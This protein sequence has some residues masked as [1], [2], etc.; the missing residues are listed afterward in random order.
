MPA[1]VEAKSVT[2]EEVKAIFLGLR[3]INLELL[4]E[5]DITPQTAINLK[6]PEIMRLVKDATAIIFWIKQQR[7]ALE[8][9]KP[10]D[11]KQLTR[12][13]HYQNEI[14]REIQ[15][16]TTKYHAAFGM[17]KTLPQE[18]LAQD[19]LTI[20]NTPAN[21]EKII[22][23][24]T[25]YY[26]KRNSYL[27][28]YAVKDFFSNGK[29]GENK[30]ARLTS[31]S[32]TR[33][34][35]EKI[36]KQGYVADDYL[37]GLTL[38][39]VELNRI[40]TET[41]RYKE[42]LLNAK[43]FL[44]E[45]LRQDTD[46]SVKQRLNSLLTEQIKLTAHQDLSIYAKKRLEQW[47]YALSDRISPDTLIQRI[48]ASKR[49]ALQVVSC[50]SFKDYLKL[51]MALD[52]EINKVSDKNSRLD[53]RLTALKRQVIEEILLPGNA[54][55]GL[56][57]QQ[58]KVLE[59]CGY[60]NKSSATGLIFTAP[61]ATPHQFEYK[62]A[63]IEA[64]NALN[65]D[66]GLKT[67]FQN[68]MAQF[69]VCETA[70]DYID[71]WYGLNKVE[72]NIAK[73]AAINEKI[74]NVIHKHK[75]LVLEEIILK[76]DFP[77]GL[78]AKML[79]ELAAASK[80]AAALIKQLSPIPKA[81]A[82]H[83]K[84]QALPAQ[85]NEHL[86]DKQLA[87]FKQM[88]IADLSAKF[89]ANHVLGSGM[90][91]FKKSRV[92]D[93]FNI[94]EAMASL[95]AF[96]GLPSMPFIYA[97]H[98]VGIEAQRKEDR[99]RALDAQKVSNFLH[100][101]Q[102]KESLETLYELIAQKI[103]DK[104]PHQILQIKYESDAYAGSF[105]KIIDKLAKNMIRNYQGAQPE[106]TLKE[107]A[108]CAGDQQKLK[109]L[110][111]EKF[112]DQLVKGAENDARFGHH[113]ATKTDRYGS[114]LGRRWDLNSMF[115]KTGCV[116]MT[117]NGPVFFTRDGA[118]PDKYGYSFAGSMKE[119]KDLNFK[120]DEKANQNTTL[121]KM[122]EHLAD[123]HWEQYEKRAEKVAKI[124]KCEAII[125]KQEQTISVLKKWAC[126]LGEKIN[127]IKQN[128]IY[129]IGKINRLSDMTPAQVVDNIKNTI[130]PVSDKTSVKINV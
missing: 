120:L 50:A 21:I 56:S 62:N 43:N 67:T 121:K 73:S 42:L 61:L 81:I 77:D 96:A 38:I 102:I 92:G 52:E 78:T 127:A 113:V 14:E 49:I 19:D 123:K 40:V 80:E 15:A 46:P 101:P 118:K 86:E 95:I 29:T 17:D 7:S 2:I 88:L 22:A 9:E 122:Y 110:W 55:D 104:Y 3:K 4:T 115:S 34:Y 126:A 23:D 105:H 85:D 59:A 84:E 103:I 98:I 97:V 33:E 79:K 108:D 111:L 66:S 6:M 82:G 100:D 28:K 27:Q 1:S 8:R 90:I 25:H 72:K 71:Y 83:T 26:N 63:F 39:G 109:R 41:S 35:F 53:Q 24:L 20:Q 37:I 51:L 16:L 124:I 18:A 70:R 116:L 12:F 68:L 48:S 130:Y 91:S 106:I 54:T 75:K 125:E 107:K 5:T 57:K 128:C 58:Y 87:A 69:Y 30:D 89:A 44:V 65:F 64:I 36:K 13:A 99:Q 10:G 112:A 93:I 117:D 94:L 31:V 74:K 60:V 119:I 114:L 47:R 76:Q 11:N 129:L 45:T 32:R